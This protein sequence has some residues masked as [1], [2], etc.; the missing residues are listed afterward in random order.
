MG[1]ADFD[2]LCK[3]SQFIPTAPILLGS[4]TAPEIA[5]PFRVTPL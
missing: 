4:L 5:T 1:A 3:R 2:H